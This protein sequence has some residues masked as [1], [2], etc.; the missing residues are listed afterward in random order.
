MPPHAR[1]RALSAARESASGPSVR[2]RCFRCG[3]W[4]TTRDPIAPST[5][6]GVFSLFKRSII[7]AYHQVSHKHLGAYLDEFEFRFNNREN[8]YLF[9]DT[10]RRLLGASTVPYRTL[11]SLKAHE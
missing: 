5:V 6:E 3:R 11:I 1:P 9:R 10:L 4:Y 7:G 2:L 8:P